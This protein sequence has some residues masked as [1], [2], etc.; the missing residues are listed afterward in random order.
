[1]I[2][3]ALH[4]VRRSALRFALGIL[5]AAAAAP[6]GSPWETQIRDDGSAEILWRNSGVPLFRT[7]GVV[8]VDARGTFCAR[9][10]AAP[11][12]RFG[13]VVCRATDTSWIRMRLAGL[14]G[15]AVRCSWSMHFLKAIPCAVFIAL[16]CEL[17]AE[18]CEMLPPGPGGA[19]RRRLVTPDGTAAVVVEAGTLV[20]FTAQGDGKVRL[21]M[22]WR[23][24]PFF[25]NRVAAAVT[26][27]PESTEKPL[28]Q[29]SGEQRG[30]FRQ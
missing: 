20:E 24:D 4:S 28:A 9:S 26:I 15:G 6:P 22:R 3:P 23:Y 5:L 25:G 2:I 12:R 19:V 18:R 8:L 1:M 30:V 11:P 13:E 29:K 27:V 16:D 17:H 7:L 21:R 14:P 10:D